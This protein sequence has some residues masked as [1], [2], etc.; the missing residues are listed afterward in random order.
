MAT[1]MKLKRYLNESKHDHIWIIKGGEPNKDRDGNP[2]GIKGLY[3]K[4]EDCGKEQYMTAKNKK[5]KQIMKDKKLI[6]VGNGNRRM[7][8]KDVYSS[9]L[10]FYDKNDQEWYD[11]NKMRS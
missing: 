1:D 8:V 4:C 2:I 3:L 11:R 6:D 9:G 7:F 5:L 10:V